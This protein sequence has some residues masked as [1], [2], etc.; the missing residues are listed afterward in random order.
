MSAAAGLGRFAAP[1]RTLGRVSGIIVCIGILGRF[2]E[3]ALRVNRAGFGG[4]AVKLDFTTYWAAARLL[5]E[6]RALDA[7]DPAALH[8]AMA[9]GPAEEGGA[10]LW[11][12]PAIWQLMLAPLGALPFSVAYILFCLVSWGAWAAVTW[13][14]ASEVPGGVGFVVAGPAVLVALITGIN[15]LLWCAGLVAAMTWAERAR[16]AR[17]GLVLGLLTIKPQLGLMVPL[18]LAARARWAAIFWAAAAALA[19]TGLGMAALGPEHQR[20]VF[21]W[22]GK[23]AELVRE[24]GAHF[25]KMTSWYALLRLSGLGHGAALAVQGAASLAA[26]A[27]VFAVWRRAAGFDLRMAALLVAVPLATPYAYHYELIFA[28]PAALYLARDG[29]GATWSGRL[30]LLA[31]WL[32]PLPGLALADIAPAVWYA[33]PL[34]AMALAVCVRRSIA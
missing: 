33:P 21:V 16:P 8:A 3:V 9:L 24:G 6:G 5:L 12:Y 29:V 13:R 10:L 2:A 7:F 17:A 4:E 32:G 31:L 18:A 20:L 22:F 1:M 30:L 34:L 28:L 11:H 25:D 27:A 15:S 26:A 14:P 23:V 19:L